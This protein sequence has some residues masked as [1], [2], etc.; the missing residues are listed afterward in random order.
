MNSASNPAGERQNPESLVGRVIEVRGE[1]L[2]CLTDLDGQWHDHGLLD[3][4]CQMWPP[5]LS[6][7]GVILREINVQRVKVLLDGEVRY[8]DGALSSGFWKSIPGVHL[9]EDA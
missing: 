9:L 6:R 2:W 8:L 4:D 7:I 1:A 5:K 3:P